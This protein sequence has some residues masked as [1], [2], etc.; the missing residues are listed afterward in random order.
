[1]VL[2]LGG[3][4]ALMFRRERW[5]LIGLVLFLLAHVVYSV[6]F[7]VFNGFHVEDIATA[8]VLLALAV[9]VYLY[10][11]PGLG[12]MQGPVIAYILGICF[13]VNRAVSTFFGE[14]F[15]ATQAWLL[16]VGAALFFLSDLVLAINRFRRELRREPMGL[17]LY[18]GGQAL[19]AL[20]PAYF[21]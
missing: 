2:S 1:L 16:A 18:Y 15:T 19:I 12:T 13:M 21:G 20:A 8:G 9:G 4:V 10:L 7:T 11:Q 17:L 5:F 14:A 6:G 3:D